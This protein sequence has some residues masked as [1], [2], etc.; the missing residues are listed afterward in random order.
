MPEQP[1][2]TGDDRSTIARPIIGPPLST[3][4]SPSGSPPAASMSDAIGVPMR[5]RKFDG[6]FMP[7]PVTVTIRSTSGLRFCTAS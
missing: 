4:T 3:F 1:F 2:V 5:T 6:R 7:L